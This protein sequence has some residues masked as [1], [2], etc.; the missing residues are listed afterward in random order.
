MLLVSDRAT[1]NMQIGVVAKLTA[2][3]VDAIRFYERRAP[4][5]PKL[6]AQWDASG[7]IPNDDVVRLGF[8]R[9]MQGLGFSLTEIRQ[10]LELREHHLDACLE[11]R[12][13]LKTKLEKVQSKVRELE[14][15]E[16][17]L[18]LDLRKCNRELK[19]RQGHT[20]KKCPILISANGETEVG[21]HP[22]VEFSICPPNFLYHCSQA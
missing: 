21:L 19:H 3:T 5:F 22:F 18:A 7:S 1:S 15:L 16:R 12:D 11:V 2:L 10:L 13:L 14:Q 9:Q 6:L 8:I 4:C 17:E 20:P